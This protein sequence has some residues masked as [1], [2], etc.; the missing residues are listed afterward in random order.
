MG[1]ACSTEGCR[2][3]VEAS[4]EDLKGGGA[5]TTCCDPE[6]EEDVSREVD[7]ELGMCRVGTGTQDLAPRDLRMNDA[8]GEQSPVTPFPGKDCGFFM[9]ENV[10]PHGVAAELLDK[11]EH[12]VD[13]QGDILKA[14]AILSQLEACLGGRAEWDAILVSP[15]FQR[16]SE[17]LQ[18][19]RE[20]GEA[21]CA[22][23]G[24]WIEGYRDGGKRIQLRFDPEDSCTVHYRVQV[25]IPASLTH[26]MA[27]AHEVQLMQEWNSTVT[28]EPK[29]IGR[30][31]AH[32]VLL[33][34]QMS[35]LGGLY[36]FDLLNEIQRFTDPDGGFIA[37]LIQSCDEEHPCFR[38]PKSGHKRPQTRIKNVWTACGPEHTMM[39][40]AGVL[41]LPFAITNWLASTVAALAGRL[42]IGGF[43]KNSLRSSA[44]GSPWEGPLRAD[45]LGIYARLNQCLASAQSERRCP[46]LG[47]TPEEAEI[48]PF[49]LHPFFGRQR[50]SR[51]RVE[52]PWPAEPCA[53][54]PSALSATRSSPVAASPKSVSLTI[55]PASSTVQTD[56]TALIK[57][58]AYNIGPGAASPG[59]A[60]GGKSPTGSR[61]GW[62]CCGRRRT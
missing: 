32:Y 1:V 28:G 24:D 36:K 18:L 50:L 6:S 59:L 9:T 23:G 22:E 16:F 49:D 12:L 56:N 7:M 5:P 33:N 21:C 31:T 42:I 3:C 27:I 11:A 35:I 54:S 43:V 15:L 57:G 45:K 2:P 61:R 46:R 38:K 14:E 41:K 51:T 34:Y 37:E 19:F 30:R 60:G 4:R 44:P 10:S 29:T 8:K 55:P 47:K 52:Q 48:P 40:Q 13:V 17:K 39:T 26:V 58:G 20:V 62:C 25:Q 53:G